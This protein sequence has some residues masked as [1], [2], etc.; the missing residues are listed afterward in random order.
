MIFSGTTNEARLQSLH[1]LAYL[2]MRESG[3]EGFVIYAIDPGS[4]VRVERCSGGLK[5]PDTGEG[6]FRTFSFPLR[7]HGEVT[8]R[9][10]FG[11]FGK[12]ILPY[13]QIVLGRMITGIE[14]VWSLL[15]RQNRYASLAAR[16][17]ALEAELADSKIAD[18]TLGLLERTSSSPEDLTAVVEHVESVLRAR[19]SGST[20]EQMVRELEEELDERKLAARAKAVLQNEHG[21]SEEQAHLHLRITSRR[22]RRPVREIARELLEAHG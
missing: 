12:S 1:P 5:V 10:V 11:F 4:G 6:G 14:A 7:I 19:Q 22:S 13:S 3:A 15:E 21:M 18:R 16:I 8:G 20:L 2:A 9:L 17:G